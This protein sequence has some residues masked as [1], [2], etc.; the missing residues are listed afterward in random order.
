MQEVQKLSIPGAEKKAAVLT[1]LHQIVDGSSAN[2]A[3]LHAFV[4]TTVVP[5]ID[6]MVAAYNGTLTAPKTVE[7]VVQKA[8]CFL[9]SIQAVVALVKKCKVS[10][11]KAVAASAAVVTEVAAPVKEDAAE[12][13]SVVAEVVAEVATVVVDASVASE[14]AV[15][16]VAAEVAAEVAVPVKEDAEVV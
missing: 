10:K 11:S 2:T 12:V 4:D 1:A 16:A 15:A 6:I 14:I 5:T 8:N 13:A 7:E 9:Q 3:E